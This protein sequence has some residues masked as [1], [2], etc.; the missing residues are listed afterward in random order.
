M[1]SLTGAALFRELE[2]LEEQGEMIIGWKV[3]LEELFI[4]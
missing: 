1:D 3:F 2:S 4:N